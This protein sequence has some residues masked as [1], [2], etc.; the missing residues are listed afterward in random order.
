M[1]AI[2]QKVQSEYLLKI[3]LFEERIEKKVIADHIK[4][5]ASCHKTEKHKYIP[6]KET[7]ALER[8]SI[9]EGKIWAT[10]WESGYFKLSAQVPKK[11][12]GGKIAAQIAI[13]S[14]ALVY[15]DNGVPLCGLTNGCVWQNDYKK[16]LYHI[17]ESCKGGENI[18]LFM[19]GAANNIFG[20]N[21]DADPGRTD[22][23]RHGT[24]SPEIKK[25][26]L[27][28]LDWE[29]YSL[30]IEINLLR[31]LALEL[32][33][34]NTRRSK[35]I[36]GLNNAVN[37]YSKTNGNAFETRKIITPLLNAY[38]GS[39]ALKITAIGHAHID[40]AWLWRIQETIRK[41]ARTF[42]SQIE[43]MER[44]PEYVFGASQP[45][46]YAFV[47]DQHPELYAKIKAAIKRG[48]WEA[49]G[50]M[51]VEADCNII[52]GES[53][54]RQ[55]LHGKNFYRDE[56]NVDV[57]NLWIPDV[58]G[59]SGNL[60]QIMKKSGIDYFLTQKISW[61]QFNSFPHHTFMWEGIDGSRVLTHF[62]PENT[63]NSMLYPRGL[64]ATEKNFTEKGFID[65]CV[66]LFGAGDG[67][68]GPKQELIERGNRL[69]DLE[70]LPKV[71]FGRADD[72]FERVKIHQKEL[73]TY[74][75]ELY[76]EIHRGTL[77]TQAKIKKYNRQ[78]E[79]LLRQIEA[80]ASLL[81]LDKYPA[82]ELDTLW[83]MVLTNQFHDII[84]GSSI[85]IVYKDAYAA[86]ENG[87]S[88][89][90][91][92]ISSLEAELT[93]GSKESITLFNVTS[94]PYEASFTI[95][96][97]WKGAKRKDGAP[98]LA[99]TTD[100][101]CSISTKI[102]A[103][104]SVVLQKDEN[105]I[106][107]KEN[108]SLVLENNLIRY[109][110][111]KEGTLVQSFDKE[112]SR[113]IITE[114]NPGNLFTLYDDRPNRYD[115]WD[116]EFFYR[117]MA[118]GNAEC[119]SIGKLHHGTVSSSIEMK[120]KIGESQI[121]QRAV[122]ENN[123]KRLE[124]HT[125]V[126][127]TESHKMLRVAFP[128]NLKTND[129]S[130]DIQY[131][132]IKRSTL[133]NNSHEFACFESVGHRYADISEANYGAA[134]LNNCK[135]GYYVKNGV[136]DLNLLRSPS[137]PDP[138]A[139]VGHHEFTYAFLPHN[140]DLVHSTVW[141]EAEHLNVK[142]LVLSG[143]NKALNL[144]FKLAG[145]GV[146]IAAIKKAEKEKCLIIRLCE[147]LGLE[148]KATIRAKAK[149]KETNLMEWADTG[150]WKDISKG[151]NILFSPFEIRTFKVILA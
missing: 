115:A 96:D 117:E 2:F 58:F 6:L 103:H 16:E 5:D 22:A 71:K 1:D 40:T 32:P 21:Q 97:T 78:F 64:I 82:K 110:F 3:K 30:W 128:T 70:G 79:I 69:T 126:E 146:V 11:W 59:Y 136:L 125:K 83:K 63:Y 118:V 141:K 41:A 140:G 107:A 14:E 105:S 18:E 119:I 52:S 81:P 94:L 36:I 80:L 120:F 17:V 131:G 73:A 72:F 62:P 129:A 48:Q 55:M 100:G 29:H 116:V 13:S 66:C 127:W 33:P 108:D 37:C 44:Y 10:E 138:E 90:R 112:F 34:E 133:T 25:L 28:L 124:F 24:Y 104:G 142:P 113:N 137:Y 23:K 91:S 111:S 9:N 60:P 57:K 134:L 12:K 26:R 35:I 46:L 84:P 53:M 65:E 4:F 77:T 148:T 135:Y 19:E 20:L 7:F 67:G 121:L 88:K 101:V 109:R 143:D 139:D 31:E 87:L 98:I 61:N 42:A 86:Y 122:L 76:L 38:N 132:A 130:F 15:S 144:P 151:E 102:P 149:I 68:G 150:E 92:L 114:T 45:Q 27:V 95:P 89:C 147:T 50:G 39:S 43:L 85:N 93:N 47:K 106:P 75:G 145:E 123:S 99:Q 51:W 49:Q 54:V 8:N 74:K 56:F